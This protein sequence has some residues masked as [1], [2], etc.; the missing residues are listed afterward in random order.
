MVCALY[1]HWHVPT[2]LVLSAGGMFGAWEVGVWKTLSRHLRP[3]CIVGASAGAW[4]GWMIAA[5]LRS[6]GSTWRDMISAPITSAVCDAP[7]TSIARATASA[8][9]KPVQALPTSNAP[10]PSAPSACA[11]CGAALGITESWLQLA[12]S[13]RSTC[14]PRTPASPS[15]ERPAAVAS[16]ASC[17]PG[18]A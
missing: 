14:E 15:A 11:T 8:D 16:S 17:A 3:D 1:Y 9:R 13:T 10:A 18:S 12:T 6:R 5:V 4:N 7:D 2:A